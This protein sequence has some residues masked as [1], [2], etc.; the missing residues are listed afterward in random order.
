MAIPLWIIAVVNAIAVAFY[1][2]PLHL[3]FVTQ[4]QKKEMGESVGKLYAL[5]KL[6]TIASPLIG[7]FI[8]IRGG[9]PLLF[10]ITIALYLIVSISL[11]YLPDSRP[12]I[13]FQ[14]GKF[15]ALAR[16]YPRYILAEIGENIREEIG[17]TM[18]PIVI[19]LI[20]SS[21]LSVGFVGVLT[22]I[23]GALFIL[24]IG[25]YADRLKRTNILRIGAIITMAIWV[26]FF[27]ARGEVSFYVLTL[28]VGF[29][30]ALLLIPFNALVYDYAQENKA[31]AE[32]IV[33]RE[34]PVTL[35][36]V[37]VYGTG[38]LFVNSLHYLFLFPVFG[39]LLFWVL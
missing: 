22:K 34:V 16:R 3:F 4:A 30:G 23:G 11:L 18:L 35:A 6:I 21:I 31:P 29:F 2:Y 17:S 25:H 19:F 26:T 37:F 38:L 32:F 20:F 5:P 10:A 7:A 33:F 27:F 24:L 9:F 15:F 36:R 39:S 13:Q 8:A 12:A 14:F 1:W 28:F